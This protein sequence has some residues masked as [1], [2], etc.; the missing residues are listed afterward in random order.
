MKLAPL[1]TTFL[2]MASGIYRTSA[3]SGS[4]EI[5]FT[6]ERVEECVRSGNR[7]RYIIRTASMMSIDEASFSTASLGDCILTSKDGDLWA[8][9]VR[10]FAKRPDV[11]RHGT[12]PSCS[13]QIGPE[14]AFVS[15]VFV[16][17]H[18][19]RGENEYG[20]RLIASNPFIPP[21][22]PGQP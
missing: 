15:D 18:P 3:W 8:V 19:L 2:V 21:S 9:D 17:R 14:G 22:E 13:L 7:A 4:R 6:R 5:H 11:L 10:W 16:T 1:P 12:H 20:G